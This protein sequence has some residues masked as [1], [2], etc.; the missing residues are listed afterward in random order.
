MYSATAPLSNGITAIDHQTTVI[1]RQPEPQ[2]AYS[3]D[4][5]HWNESVLT[6]IILYQSVWIPE[7]SHR[8]LVMSR[9]FHSGAMQ[10]YLFIF[11]DLCYNITN[12]IIYPLYCEASFPLTI[13]GCSNFSH[14][15]VYCMSMCKQYFDV[16]STKE[17]FN[18]I[19]L[20]RKG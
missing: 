17:E 18:D 12:Y 9:Q 4:Y 19:R 5:M 7:Y 16:V 20:R 6:P 1:F 8:H 15:G 3:V 13:Y 10:F 2:S 11:Y 14:L